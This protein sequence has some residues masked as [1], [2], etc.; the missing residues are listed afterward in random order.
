[1]ETLVLD[2]PLFNKKI[3]IT[4]AEK[5]WKGNNGVYEIKDAKFV[6]KI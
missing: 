3:E 5:I 4:K 6:E 1:M 2:C